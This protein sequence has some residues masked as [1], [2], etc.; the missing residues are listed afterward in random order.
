MSIGKITKFSTNFLC[1]LPMSEILVAT[2][3]G[4]QLKA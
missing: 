1:T 3:G 4:D 2:P